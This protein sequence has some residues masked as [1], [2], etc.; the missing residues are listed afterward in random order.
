MGESDRPLTIISEENR[1]CGSRHSP[2]HHLRAGNSRQCA[3][4]VAVGLPPRHG[5]SEEECTITASVSVAALPALTPHHCSRYH[6]SESSRASQM[7]ALSPSASSEQSLGSEMSAT[8][9]EHTS[10]SKEVITFSL[11]GRIHPKCSKLEHQC[12]SHEFLCSKLKFIN[13]R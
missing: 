2:E 9:E 1:L 7:D 12:I 5:Q 11:F 4:L 13:K 10:F 8:A 6:A 3:E